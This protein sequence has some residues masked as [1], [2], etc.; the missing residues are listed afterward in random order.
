MSTGTALKF[1]S[2]KQ[3]RNTREAYK[4]KKH[5]LC[6]DCLERGIYKPGEIVH[7]MIELDPVNIYNPEIAL[8]FSNLRLLCR[9]CHGVRHSNK[10]DF[11]YRINV[12]GS[13]SA[14]EK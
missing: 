13:V 3:W 5:F 12:D 1:Y 6:E 10:N 2:T 7:H 9:D 8:S 11:R 14:V 4:R